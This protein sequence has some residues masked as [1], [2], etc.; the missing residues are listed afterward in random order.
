MEIEKVKI[1]FISNS[2]KFS[3]DKRKTSSDRD[4]KQGGEKVKDAY[5]LRGKGPHRRV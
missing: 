1:V 5:M 3:Y 4:V 2:L